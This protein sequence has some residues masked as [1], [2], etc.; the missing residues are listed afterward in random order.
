MIFWVYFYT[1]IELVINKSLLKYLT[2]KN[3]PSKNTK[4]L[5]DKCKS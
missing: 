5:S 1:A 3:Y 4:N 2:L